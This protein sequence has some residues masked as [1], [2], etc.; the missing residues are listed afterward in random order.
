VLVAQKINGFL[1]GV[2]Q[3]PPE[4]RPSDQSEIMENMLAHR[5]L[6]LRRR[7]PTQHIAKLS[8]ST[9]GFTSAFTHEVRQSPTDRY[10]VVVVGGDLKVYDLTTGAEQ[11]VLFPKGKDY[12]SSLKGFK[13]YTVG[14]TT[15]LLNM[16]TVVK[17][18]TAKAPAQA[19]EAL[20]FVRQADYSTKYTV[21]LN[22]ISITY[23]TADAS[24]PAARQ[25]IAT[26]ILALSIQSA[27]LA[28]AKLADDFIVAQYG[29]TL[30]V[31][32]NDGLDFTLTCSDGLAD[33]G[34]KAIKGSVQTFADLPARAKDG[35]IV[36]I[37]GDPESTA[38]DYWVSYSDDA[39][40]GQGGV[41]VECPAPGTPLGLDE[42]TMPWALKRGGKL[43]EDLQADPTPQLP[44][45]IP[46]ASTP[47]TGGFTSNPD[48]SETF[49]GNQDIVLTD[50]G[51]RIDG[52]M[53]AAD[54]TEQTLHVYFDVDTTLLDF[55]QNVTVSL[56]VDVGS[57]FVS[58]A[59]SVYESG[60]TWN[61][62]ALV[63]AAAFPSG[64]T[65]VRLQIN[66]GGSSTPTSRARLAIITVHSSTSTTGGGITTVFTS[67]MFIG[68]NPNAIYPIGTVVVLTVNAVAHTYTVAGS[69]KNGADVA[70]ALAALIAGFTV[71]T[72][73]PG[74]INVEETSGDPIT[75]TASC[76]ITQ[77]PL[78]LFDSAVT[79]VP[80]QYVGNVVRNKTDGSTGV[81]TANDVHSVT[82]ASLTGGISNVFKAGDQCLIEVTLVTFLFST[83]AWK[84]RT[85]G[86][87]S[88]CPLPSF[89]DHAL[90]E[91]F[92]YKNRLGFA[93]DTVV[94]SQSGDVLNFMRQSATDLLDSDPIDVQSSAPN[95]GYFSH[96]VEWDGDLVLL[97]SAGSQFKLKGDPILSPKTVELVQMSSFPISSTARPVALG[98]YLFA[99]RTDG[100]SNA[101]SGVSQF[102]KDMNDK[103][104]ALD[105][106]KDVPKYIVGSAFQFAGDPVKGF[107]GVRSSGAPDTLWVYVYAY[108]ESESAYAA[109]QKVVSGWSKWTF[110]GAQVISVSMLD[111]VLTFLMVRSDGVYLEKIDLGNLPTSDADHRD[112]QGST[113]LVN[114]PWTWRMSRLFLRNGQ[115]D[116]AELRGRL[117]L[118]SALLVFH[119]SCD[120]TITVTPDGR[121]ART[122]VFHSD[123]P[124]AGTQ[125]F[126][127]LTRNTYATIEVSSATTKGCAFSGLDWVGEFSTRSKRV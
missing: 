85:S 54:G 82:V 125:F 16:D 28:N 116:V 15:Y 34:L 19:H 30:Y 4:V 107:L 76:T 115:T 22:G 70:T 105:L 53:A 24:G 84:Q 45:I 14:D 18:S 60:R 63:Y 61:G 102:Y 64:T 23:T 123:T 35:M 119:D 42:T 62:E 52:D 20:L 99:G 26:D 90:N 94:L 58:H 31:A 11:T 40:P 46:Q 127:I 95:A 75:W 86:D 8:T 43:R 122:T 78:V 124:S 59:S 72:P 71:T 10:V 126:Q 117:Q 109:P 108:E 55:G 88:T 7:P 87:L 120:F 41:W 27:I 81:I 97:S 65:T 5:T 80:G 101:F 36:Q 48:T 50:E 111:G 110:S 29:S 83:A 77:P 73:T 67:R 3:R 37:A 51:Q 98:K 69:D 92:Y 49:T 6:G 112:R 32:R 38:D 33:K 113:A 89:V 121:G 56:L 74:Q 1:N 25:S 114:S 44:Q 21:S 104:D 91:V 100:L 9:V 93:G 47:A 68:F 2:S 96:S 12:L 66:Y 57:G 103:A 106:T 79:M 17:R 118:R 13:A 39:Q